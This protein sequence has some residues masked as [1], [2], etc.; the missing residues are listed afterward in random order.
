M[1]LISWFIDIVLHLDKHLT[2]LVADYHL[3]GLRDPVPDH[4]LRNRAGGDAVPAWGFAAVR[5]RRARRGRSDRHARRPGLGAADVRGVL[6]NE[7]N[8]RIGRAI[9]PRAFSGGF[10][11]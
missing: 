6:G 9:G 1:E 5:V 4:L 7:V 11:G 2:E 8:F 10:A 3:W